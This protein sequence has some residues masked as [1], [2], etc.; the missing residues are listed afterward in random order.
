MQIYGVR[1]PSQNDEILAK[2][3][4]KSYAYKDFKSPVSKKIW[5]VQGYEPFCIRDL[6]L[7][8]NVDEDDILTGK[9][10]PRTFYDDEGVNRKF[11]PDIF[12]PSLNK[13]IEVKSEWTMW[14]DEKKNMRKMGAMKKAGY[15]I[16]FRIYSEKGKLLRTI[17]PE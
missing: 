11:C 9:N 17:I 4:K 5:R 10:V 6:I 8:E 16:E 12:I 2:I 3:E 1:N 7:K 15:D 14:K 13:I